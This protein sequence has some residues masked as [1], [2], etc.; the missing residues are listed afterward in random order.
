[1]NRP[2][3]SITIFTTIALLLVSASLFTLLEGVRYHELTHLAELQTEVTLDATLSN[4][5][6][7]L[8]ETYHLLGTDYVT[9]KETLYEKDASIVRYTLLTDGSGTVF[10][11]SVCSYMKN[12]LLYEAVKEIYSQYESV[13][14]LMDASHMNGSN[15]ENAL[16]N[17]ESI[18]RVEKN[19][20]GTSKSADA[21]K[22]QTVRSGLETAKQW[23]E[24]G[25]LEL[26][27][28]DSSNLSTTEAEFKNSLLERKL[29]VGKGF[30]Q[31]EIS[32]EER[33]LLQQYLR[34]YMSHYGEEKTDRALDYEVEYLLEAKNS[35]VKNLEGVVNKLLLVRGAANYLHL[36]SS[37]QKQAKAEGLAMLFAGAS[38]NPMVIKA[39]KIGLLT[40]WA[41]AESI[42][43][44]RALLAGKRIPFIKSDEFWTTE[45]EE[46]EGIAHGFAMAKE[47]PWGLGYED[48]LGIFLLLKDD[49]EIAM[50][51]LQL[52]EETIRM[53]SMDAFFRMD[54]LVT[55]VEVRAQYS[56]EPVFPFLSILDG[57][58]E[59]EYKIF[60]QEAYGYY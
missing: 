26:V 36:I 9:A 30:C 37:P 2:R 4:Y 51:A 25:A 41:L 1:M 17:I 18:E 57:W 11:N 31:E 54:A 10:I 32:W 47:C 52:Q 53:K 35:D 28:E 46:I 22:V 58:K 3:G 12:N 19:S 16:E 13:K 43:D 29:D 15:I 56:Y 27:L 5:N 55:R 50:R 42:L 60:S 34:T 14:E 23:L 59:R 20:V 40:A 24:M 45:L 44:V 7:C 49:E 21:D 48:Y 39:V 6:N 33:I 38:L 8:W